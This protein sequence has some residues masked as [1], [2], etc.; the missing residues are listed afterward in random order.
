MG[1]NSQAGQVG[2]GI[3][4]LK[5][6]AVAATRFAR[7]RSGSLGGER[8]LL[9]PD[10]EIGGNR[11]IPG[12]Y[13]GPVT[14]G[15][16]LAFYP[17]AQMLALLAYGTLGT[18][19][20]TSVAGTNEVQT[21]TTTGTPAGGTFKLQFRGQRTGP[22]AYNITSAAL[23][24]A[25]EA[26]STIGVG[27]VACTIGPLP[28][29][30]VC[31]FDTAPY[32]GTNVPSLTVVEEALTGGATPHAVVTATTPGV[33]AIGTH[34]ITPADALPWLTVEERIGSAVSEFESFQ[35][36]DAKVNTLHLEADATGFVMG[37]ANLF[38]LSQTAGFVEQ[39]APDWDATPMM[40]GGEVLV[41]FGGSTVPANTFSMDI[42]NNLET[43]NFVLGSVF[44]QDST[45]KRREVKMTCSY[46]PVDSTLWKAAMYGGTGLSAPI[47]GPAYRGAASVKFTTYETIGDVIAGTP[48]SVLIEMPDVVVTPY[49]ISPSGDDVLS[50]DLEFTMVRPDAVVNPIT[51]TVVNDVAQV[52]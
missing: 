10:P 46:R 11:D 15:G 27:K 26:L 5:G 6:T 14:F 52:T 36:K 51:I 25:L 32:A 29:G 20:S 16:E 44:A 33:P 35:Y 30:I 8:S 18:K 13:L 43:D 45:E 17:R 47:A 31:T 1:F 37:T 28:T 40:V 23:D 3:Q 22:L 48:F 42:N 21:V 39:V 41:S 50:N 2:L 9:I 38:A 19:S 4:S 7:L 24:T 12:A 34:V 49:K